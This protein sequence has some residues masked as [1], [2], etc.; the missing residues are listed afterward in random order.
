[1]SF[2]TSVL[3]I[4]GMDAGSGGNVDGYIMPAVRRKYV[5]FGGLVGYS[6]PVKED[7][8]RFRVHSLTR[9]ENDH[10]HRQAYHLERQRPT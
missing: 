4:S 7:G 1:V 6:I 8:Q 3:T 5:H 2:A 10:E 9:S